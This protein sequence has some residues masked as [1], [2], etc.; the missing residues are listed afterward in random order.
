M[1]KA[2]DL[3]VTEFK[4]DLLLVINNSNLP[5]SVI[6]I[7]MKDVYLQVEKKLNEQIE[8]LRKEESK[9]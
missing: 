4:A 9:E 6:E 7:V 2:F 5:I 8:N 3:A 1:S